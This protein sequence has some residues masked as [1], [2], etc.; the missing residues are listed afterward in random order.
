MTYI[1]FKYIILFSVVT[2]FTLNFACLTYELNPLDN[3]LQYTS[4]SLN[5]LARAPVEIP[6]KYKRQVLYKRQKD[7]KK[8]KN[9]AGDDDDNTKKPPI[10]E[11]PAVPVG[12]AAPGAGPQEAPGGGTVPAPGGAPAPPLQ[13][14]IDFVKPV[15]YYCEDGIMRKRQ[16]TGGKVNKLI[17]C[18]TWI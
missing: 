4:N 11:R 12:G 13:P 14:S 2:V 17:E 3:N 7:P 8:P 10:K 5:K 9:G 18:G 15:N 6:K 16:M 1:R